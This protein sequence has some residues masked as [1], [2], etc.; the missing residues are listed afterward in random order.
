M[1]KIKPPSVAGTFYT[2]NASELNKQIEIFEKNSQSFEYKARCTIVPHAGL[3]YSGQLAYDGIKTLDGGIKTL[4]IFA[5]AHKI[6]FE[7]L[8]LTSYDAWQTP[9]GN[10]KVNKQICAQME[11]KFSAK[12]NDEALKYEHSVEIQLPL[13]QKIFK[14]VEIVPVLIGDENYT[15]IKDIIE[16]YWED[17]Q[18]GFIISSDLS[19]FLKDVKAREIDNTTAAMI[20]NKEIQNFHTEQACGSVGIMGLVDFAKEKKYSL[21]RVGLINS[22]AATGDKTSVVGYG[23]W[24]L[25]EGEKSKFLKKYYS[26]LMI[27]IAKKSILSRFKEVC[28]ESMP[29]EVFNQWGACFVTLEK[30]NA[31][32]GCIG[33]IVAH[34]PLIEDLIKN[35]K[36]A[37]FS[38]PRFKPVTLEEAQE[39]SIAISLLSEPEKMCFENEED[40]LGQIKPYKDGIIIKDGC[41]RAVYLPSVWEELSDKKMF[42]NSLKMKANLSPGHFSKTF[43][44]YRFSCEYIQ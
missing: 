17:K 14:D 6:W 39:L 35:A 5:P 23:S 19:H 30:N 42:L 33:S 24:F 18:I 20:E 1:D 12:I 2:N 16:F 40:L 9:L 29:P 8:A 10:V 4:F 41:C 38:D 22:S 43:E 31:L 7:G 32:R 26:N 25:Y 37:A 3:I 15:K 34:R 44:A 27:E 13:I 36:S 21:I 11:E 28:F